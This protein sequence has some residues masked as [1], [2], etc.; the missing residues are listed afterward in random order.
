M[1]RPLTGRRILF[2]NVHLDKFSG[3]ESVVRD[4]TLGMLGRGHRPAV[5]SPRLGQVADLIRSRGIPVVDDLRLLQEPPDVIHGHHYIQTAE[6]VIRYPD[7]P[8][9][10]VCHGWVHW[11]ES[12]PRFPQIRRY[13]AVSEATRDRLV[14]ESGIPPELV[15][16]VPNAVDLDRFPVRTEPLPERPRRLLAFSVH[17]GH[18][19][20][21][22]AVADRLG[23]E[24]D[25]LDGSGA[26][27]T[28]DPATVLRSSD[29]VFATG[30]SAL[31]ALAV[32][33]AVVVADSTGLGGLVT[34]DRLEQMRA[35]NFALRVLT[36]PITVEAV[37]AEV[38]LYEP[39]DAARVSKV[40]RAE[41]SLDQQLDTFEALYE[42]IIEEARVSPVSATETHT[43]LGDFLVDAL[44][45]AWLDPR[46]PWQTEKDA[47][48]RERDSLLTEVEHLRD[49][50]A[51]RDEQLRQEIIRSRRKVRKARA[52]RRRIESS[53]SWQLTAPF[54]SLGSALR[55]RR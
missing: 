53:R 44:P 34:T 42:T 23:A 39:D 29:L 7:V 40:I 35:A 6:A 41:A 46:W 25:V 38:E 1:G 18:L 11:V 14:L 17:R 10:N 27:A 8:A 26:S 28:S 47:L 48:V 50:V 13:G 55:R 20:V 19:P 9:V 33:C 22:S 24:L 36:E 4:L 37:L 5:Y 49:T 54:R 12:P 21:L 52:A 16:L 15:T 3:T 31:E 43:A 30:R 45:R 32:G 2:T 51:E